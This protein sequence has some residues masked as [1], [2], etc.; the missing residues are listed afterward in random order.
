MRDLIVE[1]EAEDELAAAIDWYE[2]QEPGLGAAL[3]A[4]VDGTIGELQRGDLTGLAVPG[5]RLGLPVRRLPLDRFP[6]AVVFLDH[7]NA[8]HVIAFAHHKRRPG[9]WRHRL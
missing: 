2:E 7:A 3:M 9:Y 5:V 1:P 4:E 8:V 6:Y